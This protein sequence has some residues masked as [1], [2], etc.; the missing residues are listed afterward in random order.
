MAPIIESF[1]GSDIT[2]EMI[3]QAASLFSSHYGVWGTVAAEKMGVKEGK[4]SFSIAIN[5]FNKISNNCG[6]LESS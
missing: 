3:S 6:F 5:H 2:N 4:T 1:V